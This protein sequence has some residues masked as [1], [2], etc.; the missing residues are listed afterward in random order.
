MKV[1][2]KLSPRQDRILEYIRGFME[3]HQ[4]PPTVRDIQGGCEISS[5]SV[6]DYNLHILQ[7][8]GFLRR[9]PE[10]SRGIELVGV[11]RGSRMDVVSV[12]LVGNIAA[13][14]PLH[15]PA[16]GDRQ[17]D[18]FETMDLPSFLTGGK[19][20][21]YGLRVKGDS[22][23]DAFIADGDLVLME[24]TSQ[25]ESG[26]M[27]AAEIDKEEVTLK[28]FFLEGD[29]VRLQPENTA[30]DPIILPANRVVI[31]GRVVGVIRSL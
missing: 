5:T 10:V 7:R 21:V 9:L 24:P 12:P 4:F 25:V 30:L 18:E 2:G 8:E 27:V 11:Q 26:D 29:T 14:Q 1:K 23:I 3:D 28:R 6:V 20:N 13:G 16:A 17:T 19:T 15:I 22:M 31:R